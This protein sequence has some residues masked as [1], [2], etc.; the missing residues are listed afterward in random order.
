MEELHGGRRCRSQ[1][2][3]EDNS[4]EGPGSRHTEEMA[5]TYAEAAAF[6]AA[7]LAA[8]VRPAAPPTPADATR[9]QAAHHPGAEPCTDCAKTDADPPGTNDEGP[10]GMQVADNP[11]TP[12]PGAQVAVPAGDAGP[13]PPAAMDERAHHSAAAYPGLYARVPPAASRE[14]ADAAAGA[15]CSQTTNPAEVLRYASRTAEDIGRR[16]TETGGRGAEQT[17]NSPPSM[18]HG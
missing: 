16:G 7:D 14:A 12:T 10:R 17:A 9:L 6:P 13:P 18:A 4:R 15:P 5:V 8:D 1:G 11:R 2:G 3:A